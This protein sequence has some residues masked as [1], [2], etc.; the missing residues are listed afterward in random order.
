MSGG[1]QIDESEVLALL[2]EKERKEMFPSY[3]ARHPENLTKDGFVKVKPNKK[4]ASPVEVVYDTDFVVAASTVSKREELIDLAHGMISIVGDLPS[5]NAI[6]NGVNLVAKSI[7][8]VLDQKLYTRAYEFKFDAEVCSPPQY[9]SVAFEFIGSSL[10]LDA[11]PD[12]KAEEARVTMTLS[13]TVDK[14]KTD[15]FMNDKKLPTVVPLIGKLV[16]G[17]LCVSSLSVYGKLDVT[18]RTDG[19][20]FGRSSVSLVKVDFVKFTV[21]AVSCPAEEH[22]HVPPASGNTPNNPGIPVGPRPSKPPVPNKPGS[23]G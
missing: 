20:S 23:K 19:R 13:T 18:C 2:P 4:C 3:E 14:T 21:T 8:T 7:D 15:T 22:L 11:D 6:I 5:A 17:P 10:I 1:T 9:V 16:A 12:D